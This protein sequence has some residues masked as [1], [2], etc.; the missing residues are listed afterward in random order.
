LIGCNGVFLVGLRLDDRAGGFWSQFQAIA[1]PSESH[2]SPSLIACLAATRSK[3]ISIPSYHW[4]GQ[5]ALTW[6]RYSLIE[7]IAYYAL[8][9]ASNVL[10]SLPLNTASDDLRAIFAVQQKANGIIHIID[11]Q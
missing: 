10:S 1:E 2:S 4:I 8:L 5:F 9:T 11:F 3:G 7:V 6:C